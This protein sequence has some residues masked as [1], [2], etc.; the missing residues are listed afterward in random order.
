MDGRPLAALTVSGSAALPTALIGFLERNSV[1]YSERPD[2]ED[3]E[4]RRGL[5]AQRTSEDSENLRGLRALRTQRTSEDSE[6]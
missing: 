5:R 3:S 1:R 4:N 6:L 2:R